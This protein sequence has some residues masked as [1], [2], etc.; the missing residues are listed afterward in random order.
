[1]KD[2]TLKLLSRLRTTPGELGGLVG[3]VA[4]TGLGF[5]LSVLLGR[6]LGLEALGLY[7]SVL[8]WLLV[9]AT[10]AQ[11]GWH[12]YLERVTFIHS[13]EGRAEQ[14]RGAVMHAVRTASGVSLLVGLTMLAAGWAIL[15]RT[16]FN[17]L[18][19]GA[20]AILL[21]SL[22]TVGDAITRGLGRPL[23]SRT[24]EYLVRPLVQI[25]GIFLLY[26]GILPLAW[27]PGSTM[28][29]FLSAAFL[30]AIVT[31]LFARR[32][33]TPYR[34]AEA[35]PPT[36]QEWLG[37]FTRAALIACLVSV[38]VQV[39]TLMLGHFS[40][41]TEVSRF[42]IAQQLSF[43]LPLG[44]GVVSTL[45]ATPLTRHFRNG[46]FRELRRL[47]VRA[48][49]VSLAV[50]LP[51]ALVFAFAGKTLLMIVY[52]LAFSPAALPLLLMTAAQLLNA[53]VGITLT[54]AIASGAERHGVTA[55][56]LS[57]AVNLVTCLLLIPSM[58]ATGAA[59]GSAFS[60]IVL[61]LTLLLLLRK[62]LFGERG[63]Q[64]GK[65]GANA[66]G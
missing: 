15:D 14:L 40:V 20:P 60:L 11:A 54:I 19:I 38:N 51:P 9:G 27:S 17:L 28:L 32:A 46:E 16:S 25:G 13:H 36:R 49:L 64:D 35:T 5:I 52:G 3:R 7:Y 4:Y 8:A 2:A 58:G 56:A 24:G 48:S 18:L 61:N 63:R 66:I 12:T 47:A 62:T 45:Y 29:L 10:F 42:R 37:P 43:L 6:L 50:A 41:D 53:A 34:G 33:M 55:Q 23:A 65:P 31:F 21:L 1:M 57:V 44:L 59:L 26:F 22:S 39:G 30:A